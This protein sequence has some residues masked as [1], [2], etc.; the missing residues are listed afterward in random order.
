MMYKLQDGRTPLII[1]A[2]EG[3]VEVVKVLLGAGAAVDAMDVVGY[4]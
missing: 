4:R 3:L 1:A 2:E